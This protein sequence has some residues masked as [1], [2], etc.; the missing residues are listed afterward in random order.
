MKYEA[1]KPRLSFPNL[2]GNND[3][4]RY[5]ANIDI[6]KAKYDILVN[7]PEENSSFL[8]PGIPLVY[9]YFKDNEGINCCIVGDYDAD[10]V[11]ATSIVYLTLCN[12]FP[13]LFYNINYYIPH[14]INDGYG[15]SIS[16]ID[17]LLESGV[18]T[19]ITVDNGIK[20]HEAVKYAK[21]KE[22]YVILTD[23]HEVGETIPEA[24]ILVH[25]GLEPYPFAGISGATVAYKMCSSFLEY[26]KSD[27]EQRNENEDF[28][29]NEAYSPKNSEDKEFFEDIMNNYD[30]NFHQLS[31]Y[32]LQL[33]TISIVSDVMPVGNADETLLAV[34][35]NRYLLKKGLR[36]MQETPS[37]RLKRIF[38]MAQIQYETMDETTIGF[39]LGPVINAVGRLD[40]A[41]EAVA[42][43]VSSTDDMVILK[44]SWMIYLNNQRKELKKEYYQKVEKI[45]SLQDETAAVVVCCDEVHEGLIGII[46]GNIK[47]K[48]QKPALIFAATT[49]NG[50][51]A[52][53]GSCRS[54]DIVNI[55]QLLSDIDN[56]LPH[57]IVKFGGHAGAAGLTVLD[58]YFDEFNHELQARV[59]RITEHLETVIQ[60][61]KI[62]PQSIPEFAKSLSIIKP[63]GNGLPKP[64]LKTETTI[65]QI[66]FF[67]GSGHVKLS[68]A[69]KEEYWLYGELETFL[70]ETELLDGF[71]QIMNNTQKKIDEGATP[72]EAQKSH[73]ER[74]KANDSKMFELIMEMDYGQ[75]MGQIG[76]VPSMLEYK[77]I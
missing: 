30:D 42:A 62:L 15:L 38:Q 33:A 31:E 77:R 20:A 19:I 50:E 74:W 76:P 70:E 24:D 7:S 49:E 10:G 26:Y 1:Y 9:N 51:K 73:W 14:R 65:N 56:E 75:F 4:N 6:D 54:I 13:Q 12:I 44:T 57:A 66:D 37:W 18:N 63:L 59:S 52:W 47:D 39:Y 55:Y 17:K 53:K 23:H 8:M 32:I 72:D 40:D 48:Y 16:I 36:S 11:T 2:T 29:V 22:I 35:E 68:N 67:F 5:L 61:Q 69:F 71:K 3:L 25:P 28:F 64:I 45:I 34:N 21:E 41:T 43:L 60:Y 27:I 46:A 58:K